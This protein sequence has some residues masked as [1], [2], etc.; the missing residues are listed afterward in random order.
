MIN[1]CNLESKLSS[2]FQL[3][4]IH[5][6]SSNYNYIFLLIIVLALIWEIPATGLSLLKDYSTFRVYFQCL[7]VLSRSVNTLSRYRYTHSHIQFQSKLFCL[8]VAVSM[9]CNPVILGLLYLNMM[10]YFMKSNSYSLYWEL[11]KKTF[12]LSLKRK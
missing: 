10:V 12:N 1:F 3:Q 4:I 6:H 8:L 2:L 7:L 5:P 9:C 11:F